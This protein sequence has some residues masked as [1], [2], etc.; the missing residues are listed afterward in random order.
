VFIYRKVLIQP[1]FYSTTPS[2]EYAQEVTTWLLDN[3]HKCKPCDGVIALFLKHLRDTSFAQVN[4]EVTA[5]TSNSK[6]AISLNFVVDSV[7]L[8]FG[9]SHAL[10]SLVEVQ[11][12]QIS[13]NSSA[14][15][16]ESGW[17]L[18]GSGDCN[19]INFRS[20]MSAQYLNTK[21]DHIERAI[22]PYPCYGSVSYK[23]DLPD[24]KNNDDSE[25]KLQKYDS[26]Q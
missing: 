11:F 4:T 23:V 10:N 15:L 5:P 19:Q 3:D 16:S 8:S 25:S 22:E 14:L 18:P 7:I 17:F 26:F 1:Q 6:Y 21:H 2:E 20:M 9:S 13:V 24:S 12:S